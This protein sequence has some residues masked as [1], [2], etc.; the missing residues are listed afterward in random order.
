MAKQAFFVIGHNTNHS[1]DAFEYLRKGC[2]ALEP[3]ICYYNDEHTFVVSHDPV[4]TYGPKAHGCQTIEEFIRGLDHE[5]EED[6]SV[7]APKI[8]LF[9][10]KGPYNYD[11]NTLLG[12]VR[13][14]LSNCISML[15]AAQVIVTIPSSFYIAWLGAAK[16]SGTECIGI[17]QDGNIDMIAEFFKSRGIT[18][19]V[20]ANGTHRLDPISSITK[21]IRKAVKLRK[22]SGVPRLVYVWTVAKESTMESYLALGVDGLIVDLDSIECLVGLV[23]KSTS[24]ELA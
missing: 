9:D 15:K 5:L 12:I 10:L 24:H 23:R 17:D 3:D 16:L 22:A 7:S 19:Y 11:I 4:D 14:E 6:K 21:E 20:Y 2:N 1:N 13:D 18:R 8:V